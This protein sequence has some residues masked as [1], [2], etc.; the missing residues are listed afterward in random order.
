MKIKKHKKPP[1]LRTK[2]PSGEDYVKLIKILRK[3]R[4]HTVCQ[5]AK[6]P[7]MGECFSCGKATFMILGD[8]CTRDCRFCAVTHGEP[9]GTDHQ[10]PENL[11]LVVKELNL[12]YVVITSV[13]RD[14]LPDGGAGHFAETIRAVRKASPGT[15]I[16]VLIPDFKGCPHALKTVMDEKPEVLNHNVE[17]VPS[18]YS[19]A[20]PQAVYSRSL[21][22]IERAGKLSKDIVIK[23][24]IMVGLGE[25]KE[26]V[27]ELMKD[28]AERGCHIL[29]I[30]QYLAPSKG[31]LPVA[32]YVKPEEFNFYKE[33]GEAAGIKKVV[34]GPLIRSSYYRSDIL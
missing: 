25:K 13:T 20:R 12:N 34:S 22:L 7:N 11:A 14:D 16:E 32:E 4:L 3:N 10:E 31:H 33:A 28:L 23:S 21:E 8:I 29:T 17:T 30:G 9:V 5:E 19:S 2:L 27:L 6:C 26:E 1:W 15:K 24:G 18:L